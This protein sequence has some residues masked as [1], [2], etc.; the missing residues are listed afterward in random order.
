M[1]TEDSI[2][3]QLLDEVRGAKLNN[4][5]VITERH[6][7]S[8]MREKR[9]SIIGKSY[10]RDYLV[11]EDEF[12]SFGIVDLTF[13]AT[14]YYYD[15]PPLISLKDNMGIR[16]LAGTGASIPVMT[17]E[18]YRL[19]GA[20]PL[21]KYQPRAYLQ[22]QRLYVVGGSSNLDFM[23][24]GA[25]NDATRDSIYTSQQIYLEAVLYD[26]SGLSTYDWTN[27]P[28]PLAPELISRLKNDI[29]RTSLASI[30]QT[31]SDE[32]VNANSD[33]VRYHDRG[34]VQ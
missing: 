34:N 8:F 33:S 19:A 3:Y 29:K 9:A 21:Q 5:E 4:D 28:Y 1:E 22:G 12:Q 23:D 16:I 30:I 31:K 11:T 32:V 27:D 17:R 26:P 18:N 13:G 24:Q 14:S 6:I 7:R 10:N 15:V 25:G 20:N 2:V